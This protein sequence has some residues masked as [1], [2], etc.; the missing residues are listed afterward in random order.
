MTAHLDPK[1][2]AEVRRSVGPSGNSRYN[3]RASAMKQRKILTSAGLVFKSL[4][5]CSKT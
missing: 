2:D 5:D 4:V 3:S 1:E